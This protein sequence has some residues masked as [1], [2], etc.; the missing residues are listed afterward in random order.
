MKRIMKTGYYTADID[1]GVWY[2]GKESCT[3]YAIDP[4]RFYNALEGLEDN[5]TIEC[6]F[7]LD[8]EDEKALLSKINDEYGIY[9]H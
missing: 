9:L 7:D 6:F 2:R 1:S 8:F 3:G 5:E 4:E